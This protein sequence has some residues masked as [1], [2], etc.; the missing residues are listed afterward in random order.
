MLHPVMDAM[1]SRG[2]DDDF[3][4]DK[5]KL[6]PSQMRDP[7]TVLPAR[8]I[9]EFLAWATEHSTD[10]FFCTRVGRHMARGAWVAVNPLLQNRPKIWDV[11][12]RFSSMAV[13]QGGSASYRL[14]AEASIALWKLTRPQGAP[15]SSRYADAL[16]TGFFVDLIA[17]AGG[18]RFLPN[19]LVVI[20][21]G[22]ELI[23]SDI[24]PR[25]SVIPG[26][27]GMTIRFPSDWLDWQLAELEIASASREANLPDLGQTD[28][29]ARVQR[30][31]EQNLSD[32]EFGID[33]V[34]EAIG[35]P[36][37]K[38][39]RALRHANTSVADLR[40]EARLV[41]AKKLLTSGS[42]DVSEIATALGYANP[43]NFAR[44]F[45]A[46]TGKSP[47]AFRARSN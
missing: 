5:L 40:N 27:S 38:L 11:L 4:A 28:L 29:K 45:R 1:S 37:W 39:Q 30:L 32:A 35:L 26:T 36:R 47:S 2:C 16:A 13:D 19:E 43:S 34:S 9:Y 41:K 25:T 14:E 6:S 21:P 33:D 7:V 8:R 3:L 31:L 23:P 44:A 17:Q 24:L 12:L 18:D 42:M 15:E 10:P 22:S 20:V 46:R